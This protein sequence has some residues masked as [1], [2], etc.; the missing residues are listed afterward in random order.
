MPTT[1]SCWWATRTPLR[2]RAAVIGSLRTVGA[3]T[4]NG[5]GYG[6][7][8]YGNIERQTIDP[9]DA[10]NGA[11]YYTGAMGTATGAAEAALGPPAAPQAGR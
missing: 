7:V 2:I 6:T 1:W 5:T 8:M 4:W 9:V 3:Q 11:V 10:I